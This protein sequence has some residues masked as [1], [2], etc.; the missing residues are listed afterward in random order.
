[1]QPAGLTTARRASC[2]P[3]P[4]QN[5]QK[6]VSNQSEKTVSA[7]VRANSSSEKP[8]PETAIMPINEEQLHDGRAVARRID[9]YINEHFEER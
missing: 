5:N 1:C 9:I 6:T 7:N 2:W 4:H 3:F 8:I